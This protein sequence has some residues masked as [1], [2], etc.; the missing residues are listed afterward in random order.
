M[1]GLNTTGLKN[2]GLMLILL[3]AGLSLSLAEAAQGD[4]T[5]VKIGITGTIVANASCKIS[6]NNPISVEFGDV[7]ISE[8]KGDAYRKGIS[9][10]VSCQGDSGGKSIQLQMSGTGA[11]FD[12]G[13]L[14]TDASGLGIKI[15][16][17]GSQMNLN[18]WYDLDPINKPTLEGVLVK[19][20]EASF[21]NGQ[22]FNASATLKVAYN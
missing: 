21:T 13:L 4:T 16:K 7:Y 20:D 6:G 12:G 10:D 3:F 11:S 8:I 9:Y 14:K 18:Q 19:Q 2:V 22:E 1:T 5:N 17:D 15:L